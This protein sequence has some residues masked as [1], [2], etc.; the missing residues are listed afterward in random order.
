M[1]RHMVIDSAL[2]HKLDSLLLAYG[3]RNGLRTDQIGP[4][5]GR[6]FAR[7]LEFIFAEVLRVPTAVRNGL[8]LMLFNQRAE[9]PINYLQANRQGI[10]AVGENCPIIQMD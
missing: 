1:G 10:F 4:G 3:M 7:R 5:A 6:F 2:E 9:F 8:R